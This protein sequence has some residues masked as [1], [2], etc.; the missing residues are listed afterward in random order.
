MTPDEKL[1]LKRIYGQ[2]TG[3]EDV[4]AGFPGFPSKKY[5]HIRLTPVDFLRASNKDAIDFK[6]EHD[7]RFSAIE[8]VQAELAAKLDR[9]LAALA[10]KA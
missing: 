10:A 3:T 2:L 9:V 4:K 1:M 8:K 7:S 6:Q 5:P